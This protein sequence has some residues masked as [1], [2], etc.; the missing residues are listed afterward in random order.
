MGEI[1]LRETNQ[2]HY[3]VV[4]EDLHESHIKV[5]N[6]GEEEVYRMKGKSWVFGGSQLRS[7]ITTANNHHAI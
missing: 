2:N 7:S 4:K 6:A 1:S 3:K 5:V